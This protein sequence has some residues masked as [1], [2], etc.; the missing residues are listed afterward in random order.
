MLNHQNYIF[1]SSYLHVYFI[2]T[3]KVETQNK[4]NSIIFILLL[5]Y[6]HISSTLSSFKLLMNE[7][8]MKKKGIAGCSTFLSPSVI[9]SSLS[10]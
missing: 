1:C 8:G 4:T 6:M 3:R 9:T 2:L 5:N 10:D 7:K